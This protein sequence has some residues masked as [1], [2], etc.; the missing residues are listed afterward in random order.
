MSILSRKMTITVGAG[1]SLIVRV[2]WNASS[3]MFDPSWNAVGS[4]IEKYYHGQALNIVWMTV[5]TTWYWHIC[6]GS[7]RGCETLIQ[8]SNPALSQAWHF[9]PDGCQHAG[10]LRHHTYRAGYRKRPKHPE[11]NYSCSSW[12][13]KYMLGRRSNMRCGDGQQRDCVNKHE[14]I[15]RLMLP[16]AIHRSVSADLLLTYTELPWPRV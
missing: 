16:I 13:C 6:A 5:F 7:G 14:C 4:S 15:Y 2:G 8:E 12:A 1:T 11:A 10:I 3:M 9:H